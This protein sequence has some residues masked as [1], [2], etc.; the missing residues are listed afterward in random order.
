M[1]RNEDLFAVFLNDVKKVYVTN[2]DPK[3][4]HKQINA[5]GRKMNGNICEL[6]FKFY[7][8]NK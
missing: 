4:R 1:H 3:Q 7:I 6:Y 5:L 8:V 2:K